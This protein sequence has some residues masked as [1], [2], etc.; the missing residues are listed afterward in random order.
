MVKWMSGYRLRYASESTSNLTFE[1]K[2]VSHLQLFLRPEGH[3]M[4]Q[5]EY[6]QVFN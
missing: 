5:A 1:C 3:N 6:L 2:R 4:V